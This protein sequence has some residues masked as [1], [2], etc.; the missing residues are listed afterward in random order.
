MDFYKLNILSWN[1]GT[2][3]LTL[4]QEAAYLRIVNAI[5][6]Y[7]RPVRANLR[8]LGGLWRCG[9]ERKAKRLLNELVDA[10]KITVED[11]YIYNPRALEEASKVL[12]TRMERASSGREGGLQ[13]GKSRSNALKNNNHGEALASTQT[14]Q[15]ESKRESKRETQTENQNHQDDD[16]RA[17]E[18]TFRERLVMAM[19]HHRSGVMPSGR[20]AGSQADMAEANRW[21][22]LPGMTEDIIVEEVRNVAARLPAPPMSFRYF[23]NAMAQLSSAL[24]APPLSQSAAPSNRLDRPPIAK[25]PR[26][27]PDDFDEN[28]NR[29]RPI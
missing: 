22:A 10:G 14:N 17:A 20:L 1:Q 11:G 25:R 5:M 2:D 28:G 29:I 7:E 19:G 15:R 6:L 13:S 3:D 18:S 27:N 21:L 24:C 26:T 23:T 8:V 12:A 16:D 4:E 9:S